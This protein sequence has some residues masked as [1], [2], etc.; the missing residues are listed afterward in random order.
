M[1]TTDYAR[2][3]ELLGRAKNALGLAELEAVQ[4]A[5][6]GA[7]IDDAL[8]AKV[9]A[10]RASWK[11]LEDAG[12]PGAK[13]SASAWDAYLR[14]LK[15][16]EYERLN[17]GSFAQTGLDGSSLDYVSEAVL[18]LT[19]TVEGEP[20]PVP[21]SMIL[22]GKQPMLAM[23]RLRKHNDERP[24]ISRREGERS[25]KGGFKIV[26]VPAR[27]HPSIPDD[28]IRFYRTWPVTDLDSWCGRLS[29]W[30]A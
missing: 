16:R 12:V 18:S 22:I 25:L 5:M 23:L 27:F 4:A 26:G 2:F 6:N 21:P 14:Q 3:L 29:G 28:E 17:C 11:M 10:C 7:R 15:G 9:V 13:E 1:I 30:T 8:Q 24:F 19:R 20:E